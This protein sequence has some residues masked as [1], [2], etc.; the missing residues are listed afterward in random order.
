[1]IFVTLYPIP[2]K[3]RVILPKSNQTVFDAPSGYVGLYTHSF[4]LENLRLPLTEFFCKVLEYFQ[5]HISRLDPFGC[6]KLTTFVVMCLSFLSASPLSTSFEGSSICLGLRLGRYPMSFRV[7]PD[8]ILFLVGL[9]SS[10]EHGQ[11]RPMILVGGKEI[12]FRNFIYT[13]DD[14][15]LAFLPKEPSSDFGIAARIKDRKCKTRGGS[16]RSPVKRKLAPGTSTSRATRAKTYSSK[17]DAPFLTV[18]DDDDG[19]PDVLELKYVTACH[20]KI[21]AITPLA[22]MNHLDNRIDLELLDLYDRCYVIKKLKGEFDV[23]KSRERAREEECKGLQVKCEAAMTEIEKNPAMVA[24]QE[25][26]SALST[27]SKVTSLEAEKARLEVV[28]VAL[29]KEVEELKQDRRE[30]VSKVVPYVVMELVH[31]DDMGS[32][33]GKLVSSVIAYGRCWA[34]EQASNNLATAT[35]H[36]LD[37]FVADPLVPI[38][39]LLLKKPLTLQRPA[40]SRTHVPLPSSQRATPSSAPVSNLMSPPAD[41]SIVKPQSSQPH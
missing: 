16:S 40:P 12:A 34:F 10:W 23:M 2:S 13:E 7:F 22:W 1:M 25:K 21:S 14:E 6:A 19:L 5:V 27:E 15:D 4:S 11:Q 17:D 32:L 31:S 36:W 39:A 30:V 37:V 38:K 24:L 20:L 29:R 33:I 18:S 41:A 3:Y 35:F 9:K 8:P 28:K 26:I